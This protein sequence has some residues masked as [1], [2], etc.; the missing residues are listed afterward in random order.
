MTVELPDEPDEVVAPLRSRSPRLSPSFD[1]HGER[2]VRDKGKG[3]ARA[4]NPF[5]SEYDRDRLSPRIG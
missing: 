2:Q 3:K 4:V 1:E 5:E